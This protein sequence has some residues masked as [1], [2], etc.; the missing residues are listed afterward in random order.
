M[1]EGLIEISENN[2]LSVFITNENKTCRFRLSGLQSSDYP[3]LPESDFSTYIELETNKFRSM[4]NKSY[5]IISPEIKFNVAGAIL[6][7]SDKNV[8]LIATDSHRLAYTFYNAGENI[9]DEKASFIISRKTLLE[10]LKI[11]EG[12][13]IKFT[14]LI[15]SSSSKRIFISFS[16]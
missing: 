6:N 11:S 9:S 5:Y 16:E 10:L 4:I 15:C 8:E 2:D 7:I 1:P 12:E 13:F 3:S 14:P